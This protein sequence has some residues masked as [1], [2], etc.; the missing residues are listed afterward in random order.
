M[1]YT[2]IYEALRIIRDTC[3]SC[4][5]CAVC[6]FSVGDDACGITNEKPTD[7]EITMPPC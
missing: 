4:D 3:D 5:E 2:E 6:P 1:N 7:W